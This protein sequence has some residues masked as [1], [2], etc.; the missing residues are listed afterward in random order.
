M[1]ERAARRGAWRV[2]AG[3]VLGVAL[4][5][6]AIVF[7]ARQSG[8]LR[9]AW[10]AARASA[11]WLV[12]LALALPLANYVVVS[13]SFWVQMRRLGPVP[14]DEMFALIGLAWLL[15]FLPMRVGM[16]SRLAYHRTYHGIALRDSIRVMIVGMICGAMSVGAGLGA[17]L[18][19]GVGGSALR[20][21]I[22]LAI[23]FVLAIPATLALQAWRRVGYLGIVFALRYADFVIWTARYAIVFAIVGHPVSLVGAAAISG[24]C[25]ITLN[26]PIAGNGL[27]L[28]EWAVGLVASRLPPGVLSVS[29]T[30]TTA[31]GLAADLLNRAAELMVAPIVGLISAGFLFHKIRERRAAKPALGDESGVSSSQPE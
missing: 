11:A 18:L 6:L 9:D 30:M 1:N 19:A 17:V 12:V 25:Q 4:L 2:R 24:V 16:I 23:P 15:N 20:A 31:T 3:Y 26:V 7:V 22:A 5:A 13:L 14:L 27:G 29:G 8:A 28:R 21:S 10:I